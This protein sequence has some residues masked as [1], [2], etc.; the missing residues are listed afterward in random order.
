ML[1]N[2][3]SARFTRS[4]LL[5]LLPLGGGMLLLGTAGY[6]L[7]EGWTFLD[8]LYMAVITL[9]TVGFGETRPLSAGGR[10]FTIFYISM[11]VLTIGYV[12][13]MVA[14][15]ALGM[16]MGQQ[17]RRR[18]MERAI[19]RMKDHVIVCGYGR[20]GETAAVSL[21]DS[22]KSF[23]IV[24]PEEAAV[25]AAVEAGWLA[26]NGDATRDETLQ[27]AGISQASGLLVCT[28]SDVSNLFIVL[29]ARALRADLYIV[30]RTSEAGNEAKMRRA[31]ANKVVSPFQIGG[32]HMANCLIRPNVTDFLDVV[33]LDGGQELWLE[34][35][36]V[37]NGSSLEGKSVHESDMR[38][39]TGATLVALR[40]A[41]D[42]RTVTPSSET[43]LEARDELIVIGTREQLARVEDMA[44]L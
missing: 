35:I 8:A 24:D 44:G 2:R 14:E 3:S 10:V 1:R 9:T 26:V 40:Q 37:Q 23:V 16:A 18:R 28:G 19:A 17:L 15:Y 4:P 29:S 6:M 21:K 5:T 41:R 25:E 7:I 13:A 42:G 30:V 34:E 36:I 12:T 20:V 39:R 32:R 38:R 11:G 43:R 22:R 27:L 33:T 31:G